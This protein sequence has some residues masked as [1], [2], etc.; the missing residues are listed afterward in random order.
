MNKALEK[1]GGDP[2][3]KQ[4]PSQ[5]SKN[6]KD[7]KEKQ[8]ENNRDQDD[9]GKQEKQEPREPQSAQGEP[10]KEPEEGEIDKSQAA[11]ILE[12]MAKDEKN[13]RDAI[14]AHQ[15]RRYRNAV[16]AKDW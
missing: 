12:D 10:Q 1:L 16:P 3:R 7:Q 14:K 13:L 4:E 8:K 11:S 2:D 15:K 5:D 6:G 9:S